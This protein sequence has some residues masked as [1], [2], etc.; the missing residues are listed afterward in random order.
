[1]R[2]YRLNGLIFTNSFNFTD[3]V[4]V[5]A[6]LLD[7]HLLLLHVLLLRLLQGTATHSLSHLLRHDLR[8]IALLIFDKVLKI[9]L[10]VVMVEQLHLPLLNLV[11]ILVAQRVSVVWDCLTVAAC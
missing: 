9:I 11:F 2:H 6:L 4:L 8:M 7:K 3:R 1:M 5:I 10:I